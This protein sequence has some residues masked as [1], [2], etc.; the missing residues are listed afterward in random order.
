M[1]Y[2]SRVFL[3]SDTHIV[4]RHVAVVANVCILYVAVGKGP[5]FA[6]ADTDHSGPSPRE[7]REPIVDLDRGEQG[8]QVHMHP[9]SIASIDETRCQGGVIP[10]GRGSI[11][12]D[13]AADRGREW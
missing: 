13:D 9:D 1:Q 4:V 2:E 7:S 3:C 10:I 6:V 8:T 5:D 12:L 11:E